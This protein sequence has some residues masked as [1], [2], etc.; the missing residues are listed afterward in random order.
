MKKLDV[1][2]ANLGVANVKMHNLHWN[3]KGFAFPQVHVYLEKLYDGINEKFDA[4]AEIQKMMGEYPKASLKEYLEISSIKELESK[5]YAIE[6]ALNIALE[7]LKDMK[8]LALEI[9]EEAGK[10]DLFQ[11]SNLMEDHVSEYDKEIWFLE[12][13]IK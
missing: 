5:D 6:E 11:V 10:D 7:Y 12:S 3:I 4:V 8:K 13:M 2:L 1:Y 9:R